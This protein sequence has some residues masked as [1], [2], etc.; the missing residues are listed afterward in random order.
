MAVAAESNNSLHIEE[1]DFKKL[2][3]NEVFYWAVPA[4]HTIL[5][6]RNIQLESLL[7]YKPFQILNCK[8][9]NEYGFAALDIEFE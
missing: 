6:L 2:V 8:S 3:L 9:T 4:V 7:L 5:L 1:C